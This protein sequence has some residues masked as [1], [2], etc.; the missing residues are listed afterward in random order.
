MTS[1]VALT[2]LAE[3]QGGL[4]T[5]RQAEATGMAWSTLARLSSK[6]ATVE[7]VAHGVYRMRGAPAPEHLELRAAWLQLSPDAPV[8]ERRP[9]D[10]VVSHRSA[11]ALYGLGHL[12]ADIHEF[13]LPG[14]RQSRRPDLRL[15]RGHLADAEWTTLNGLLVTRPPRIVSDLLSAREDPGAVGHVLAEALRDGHSRPSTMARSLAGH[16]GRFG[17][18]RGDGVALLRWLLDLT[19]APERNHWLSQISETETSTAPP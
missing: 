3:E 10:G 16:A 7:R 5:R 6:G 14:R 8:W 18:R 9:A 17:L 12:P 1:M 19:T 15:H 11:A 4:F 13:T 2:D